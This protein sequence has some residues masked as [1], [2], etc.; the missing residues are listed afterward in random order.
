VA[1]FI[2]SPVALRLAGRTPAGKPLHRDTS[3]TRVHS[4]VY[5]KKAEWDA[6]APWDRYL[7][8]VHAVRLIRPGSVFCLE[9]SAALLGLPIFGEPRYVHLFNE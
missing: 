3:L 8:R 2:P 4:R 9:S 7:A 6:L 5:A 1:A